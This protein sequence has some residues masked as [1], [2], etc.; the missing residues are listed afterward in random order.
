M[1]VP[2][3]DATITRY[4]TAIAP[5]TAEAITTLTAAEVLEILTARDAVHL[6]LA[7]AHQTSGARLHEI[8]QLDSTLRQQ[9]AKLAPFTADP[10]WRGSF[11]PNPNAWWWFLTAP[12]PSRWSDNYDWLW[13][14]IS[15]TCL[16]VSLALVGDMSNR[17][18]KGGPD[19][20]GALAV[21]VQSMLTL[22]TAGGAL[23]SAGQE[24]GKRIL[25][26]LD[27]PERSWQEI[28]AVGSVV[29]ATGLVGLRVALPQIA[30]AYTK[31]A[32]SSYQQGDWSSAEEHY[33]RALTL[34]PD[35]PQARLWL[36]K[37][38][39]DMQKYDRAKGEY[40]LAMQGGE[41]TAVNNLARLEI[42]DN[43]PDVAITLLLRALADQSPNP[44]R[45]NATDSQAAL[46]SPQSGQEF[47][48][49][50]S[51]L[52]PATKVA[53]LQNLGWARLEQ[54]D[55]A[56]AETALME[57]IQMQGQMASDPGKMV[58]I[59]T[60]YC[61][62]AQVKEGMG[63]PKAALSDWSMCNQYANTANPS[64]TGWDVKARQRLQQGS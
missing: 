44:G 64:E 39:E 63:Q 46:I 9:R 17:F 50:L 1:T 53:M 8:Q 36:G 5:L 42:M 37:L 33:Q 57:A 40:Q 26:R 54:K 47:G 35:N 45:L 38:Y 21:S 20:V 61:L 51:K 25:K 14:A 41:V 29:L 2:S 34:N 48:K 11:N 30:E 15:V 23:T 4:T 43:Q 32:K 6:A 12:Q 27:C 28:G 62:L 56:G 16:T 10:E 59:A 24:A 55:Y 3:L 31:W 18:L 58:A 19:T 52:D 22:L 60:P 49:P 13:N 7:D